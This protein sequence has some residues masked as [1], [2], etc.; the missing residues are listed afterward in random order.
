MLRKT[1]IKNGCEVVVGFPVLFS[2]LIL[3]AGEVPTRQKSADPVP[4]TRAGDQE[5]AVT[6]E[7]AIRKL[8]EGQSQL[9]RT[10][11]LNEGM[12]QIYENPFVLLWDPLRQGRPFEILAGFAF[13]RLEIRNP[14]PWK[15]LEVLWPNGK[16]IR[17]EKPATGQYHPAG[18]S[19]S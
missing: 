1:Q 8:R 7:T 19:G 15:R 18:F 16:S 4:G 13:N 5:V 14:G 6:M 17:V 9:D 10:V 11:F 2:A 3:Q 12:A